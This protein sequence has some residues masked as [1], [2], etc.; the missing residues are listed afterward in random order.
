MD[1]KENNSVLNTIYFWWWTPWVL[2][3]V[4]FSQ[5]FQTLKSKFI[6]SE[7]VE[8]SIETTPW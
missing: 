4:Q 5:I 6:F 1:S 7:N 8:I 2:S 3:L